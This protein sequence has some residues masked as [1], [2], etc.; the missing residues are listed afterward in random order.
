MAAVRLPRRDASAWLLATGGV[1]SLF[2]A[3][4]VLALPHLETPVLVR[5]LGVYAFC[6]GALLA[7]AAGRLRRTLSAQR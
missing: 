6:F 3:V 2:L 4:V 7:T 5:A 1:F